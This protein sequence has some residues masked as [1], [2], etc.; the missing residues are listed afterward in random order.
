MTTAQQ[1]VG[2]HGAISCCVCDILSVLTHAWYKRVDEV[3]LAVQYHLV[4]VAMLT[5]RGMSSGD[6]DRL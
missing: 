5:V 2:T 6:G 4:Y 3:M 1:C